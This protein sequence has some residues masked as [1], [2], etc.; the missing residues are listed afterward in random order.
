M[1]EVFHQNEGA[2]ELLA[3]ERRVFS[4]PAKY[5]SLSSH[6]RRV[7]GRAE[8]REAPQSRVI[9]PS[10]Y[11]EGTDDLKIRLFVTAESGREIRW[12]KGTL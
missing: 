3:G 6:V 10:P 1:A 8:Q 2:I 5:L 11:G 7:A 12:L 9:D 4:E